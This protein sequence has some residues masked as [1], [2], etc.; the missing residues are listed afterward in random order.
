MIKLENLGH[1]YGN[2]QA[3]Q[4]VNLEIKDGEIFGLIGHNGAGK[5]TAIK[6]IVSI[7]NFTEGE[8]VVDGENL[9]EHRDKIKQKITYVPDSPDMFLKLQA[10]TYWNFIA[11]VY[12]ISEEDRQK[13]INRLCNIFDMTDVQGNFIEEFSHGMRQKAFLIGALIPNPKIWILDEPMTGLDPQ[14]AFN[15]KEMM[16]EHVAE[17]NTVIFSTHVLEVAEKLCHR[18]GILR[19]G[20]LIFVGTMDELKA[21]YRGETLE[22]I[23]LD[24]FNRNEVLNSS[25]EE[26]GV[27]GED[28][29]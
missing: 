26:V 29:K 7:L 23:Y 15:L 24:M 21:K 25:E 9:K 4:K 17:G 28:E 5:S 3:L 13:R 20:E 14:A 22:D 12:G 10:F 6:S 8:I 11:D 27:N 19:K 16:K 2:K 1:N 18:I